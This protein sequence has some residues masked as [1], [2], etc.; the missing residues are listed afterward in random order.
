MAQ[1]SMNAV[2]LDAVLTQI[3]VAYMQTP[4]NFIASDVFPMIGV[5]Q[6]S[7]VYYTYD[8]NDWFRDEAQRR[9]PGTESAGSGYGLSRANYACDVFALHK[10]VHDQDRANQDRPIDLDSEAA[11]YVASRLIL[12]REIQ[13]VTDFFGTGIWGT[14][15]TGVSGA[16]AGGQFRKWSDYVNSDPLLDVEIGKEGILSTTGM[17]PNTLVLGYKAFRTLKN[18]PDL[19]DRLKYTTS[20]N[21]T[22]DIMARLFDVDRVLVAKAVKATNVEG[23]TAA[24]QFAFPD[25]ALLAHVA[26]SPGLYTP[27]AGYTFAWNGVSGGMGESIGTSSFRMDELKSTRVE[28]EAAWDNK[29]V[30]PDLGYFFTAVT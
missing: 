4:N 25:G 9:A 20:E 22:A 13:F 17:E 30:A 7:G 6:K 5:D 8:K 1:P 14:D 19:S 15:I 24:Y 2:H 29:V 10:D 27:S 3:S 26:S 11:K 18:H 23:E 21:I 12:R 28:S 16:P